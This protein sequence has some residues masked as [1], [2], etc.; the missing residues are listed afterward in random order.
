M[1]VVVEVEEFHDE[2]EAVSTENL[3]LLCMCAICESVFF[4]FRL[5]KGKLPCYSMNDYRKMYANYL[6]TYYMLSYITYMTYFGTCSTG[7]WPCCHPV[8][9]KFWQIDKAHY[10]DERNELLQ[11]FS[12]KWL[13]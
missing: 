13:M 2:R 7:V 3:H 10:D 9:F 5:W 8:V 4:I 6:C 1:V 11:L 12:G